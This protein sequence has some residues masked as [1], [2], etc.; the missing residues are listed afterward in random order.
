MP[1]IVQTEEAL[2]NANSYGSA[3]EFRDYHS[4]RGRQVSASDSAVEAA[5]VRATDYLDLR[6][7]YVGRRKTK[8]QPTQWPRSWA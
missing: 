6:F 1:L 4:A 2:P 8:E 5:L 7:R 3:Q